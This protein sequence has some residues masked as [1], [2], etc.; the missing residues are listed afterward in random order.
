MTEKTDIK[1]TWDVSD[2]DPTT[3][4][5]KDCRFYNGG[6]IA[7]ENIRRCWNQ[8]E[9]ASDLQEERSQCEK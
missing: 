8:P 4:F 5:I 6:L 2:I 7:P 3:M 1:T 9:F